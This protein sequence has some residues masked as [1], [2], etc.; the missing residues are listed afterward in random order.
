MVINK[1]AHALVTS[2]ERN[3]LITM[4]YF[5]TNGILQF[6]KHK[7]TLFLDLPKQ[8]SQWAKRNLPGYRE[9]LKTIAK[10]INKQSAGSTGKWISSNGN[11]PISDKGFRKPNA[12]RFTSKAVRPVNY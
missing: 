5:K 4:Q 11:S 1:A 2:N 8:Y 10:L 12:K 7:G 6:G 3:N 9:Q